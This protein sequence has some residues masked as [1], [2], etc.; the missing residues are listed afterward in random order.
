M[1]GTVT[2]WL[3]SPY[4]TT[5]RLSLGRLV[6][7]YG[8]LICLVRSGLSYSIVSRLFFFL[9]GDDG[10]SLSE[11]ARARRPSDAWTSSSV[12][13]IILPKKV[14]Y[15]KTST[16]KNCLKK[17]LLTHTRFANRS[18]CPAGDLAASACKSQEAGEAKPQTHRC[19][20]Q[21]QEPRRQ[22]T[23]ALRRSHQEAAEAQPEVP[24]RSQR[25]GDRRSHAHPRDRL[26][27]TPSDGGDTR[28]MSRRIHT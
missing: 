22:W 1:N 8:R 2:C 27:A 15:W 11:C 4:R 10:M 12:V 19:Q 17:W 18:V 21:S 25:D 7:L 24:L 6:P 20:L 23:L 28:P 5:T 13:V 16:G 3:S 14:E 26:P 9:G